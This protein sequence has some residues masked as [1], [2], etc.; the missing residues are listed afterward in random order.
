MA[1]IYESVFGV[2]SRTRMS[3]CTEQ[4][5]NERQIKKKKSKIK[6]EAR[7]RGEEGRCP[8]DVI[9]VDSVEMKPQYR[10]ASARPTEAAAEFIYT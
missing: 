1:Y 9:R 8:F 10:A 6:N 3:V 7:E 4:K 5:L 2:Y